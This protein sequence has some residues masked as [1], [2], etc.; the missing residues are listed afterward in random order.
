[1]FF[2]NIAPNSGQQR[3]NGANQKIGQTW[4]SISLCFHISLLKS[5]LPR[6]HTS[7]TTRPTV[8]LIHAIS[9]KH[10]T[11]SSVIRSRFPRSGNVFSRP[12]CST[13]TTLAPVATSAS[14]PSSAT[15]AWLVYLLSISLR[16]FFFFNCLEAIPVMSPGLCISSI[17]HQRSPSPGL[18]SPNSRHL[19][20][21]TL[22][23]VLHHYG[24]FILLTPPHSAW[25]NHMFYCVPQVILFP[26]R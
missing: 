18:H 6:L 17:L 22:P 8:H 1:M 21:I 9:S 13:G 19:S 15:Q 2:V 14:R 26:A 23:A 10:S 16:T 3:E 24:L 11:L 7:S 12:S 4:V 25:Q 20:I 5:I